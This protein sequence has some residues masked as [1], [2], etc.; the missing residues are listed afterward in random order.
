[1]CTDILSS[2]DTW[3]FFI[4]WLVVY[5]L[6]LLWHFLVHTGVLLL[7]TLMAMSTESPLGTGHFV[8]LT[9]QHTS[10]MLV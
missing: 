3:F 2:V 5:S 7:D 9:Y 8:S 4:S 6:I 10:A 1:M